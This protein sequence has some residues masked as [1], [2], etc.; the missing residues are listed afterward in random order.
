[1]SSER[2]PRDPADRDPAGRVATLIDEIRRHDRLY[3]EQ[4]APVISDSEYDALLRE[5][6]AAWRAVLRASDLL[7]RLGGDEFAVLLPD[8]DVPGAEAI[9]TRLQAAMP[10]RA[11]GVG[12]SVGLVRWEPG[13]DAGELLARADVALYAAKA[14]GRGGMALG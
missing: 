5:L 9:V 1:M 2:K 6:T 13:E 10:G 11:E 8:C 4:A 7:S 12:C 3:F 14:A